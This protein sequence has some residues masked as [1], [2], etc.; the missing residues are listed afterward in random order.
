VLIEYDDF[1]RA[2]DITIPQFGNKSQEEIS[3]C[4]KN[5]FIDNIGDQYERC[6]TS[7]Q[8]AAAQIHKSSR[9]SLVTVL[10]EGERGTGKSAMAAKLA[11]ES[12]FGFV[13][14]IS[15]DSMIG[16]S[17][18]QVCT[19]IH[20]VFLDSY[21]SGHS[22]IFLD[23]IER[24]IQFTPVG[25]RFSNVILQTL[26][27]MLK[28]EPPSSTKLMI[29]A[30]T[31]ISNLLE[32][33]QITTIFSV[34]LNVPQLQDKSEYKRVL[35]MYASSF[36]EELQDAIVTSITKP[37][38]LKQMLMVIEMALSGDEH[39]VDTFIECMYLVCR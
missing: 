26:L 14:M 10:L 12:N 37:I 7:L 18:S 32:N 16:Y 13:R 17:E 8:R 33:L 11:S 15:A 9:T 22:I 29:V 28:K 6:W 20:K 5:G 30:T 24:I 3:L 19:T 36:S 23:D 25:Q 35:K 38:G 4:F 21:R 34:V 31:A 2:I 39:T 1:L 27:I